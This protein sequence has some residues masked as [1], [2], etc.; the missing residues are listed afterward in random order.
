MLVTAC[1]SDQ[2]SGVRLPEQSKSA[3]ERFFFS[4]QWTREG[5]RDFCFPIVLWVTNELAK[6]L[7]DQAADFWSWRGGVFEFVQPLDWQSPDQPGG[8]SP[9]PN[10]PFSVS[11]S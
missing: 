6:E 8:T 11:R 3:E 1:G 7:A 10:P 2:L 9:L 5:L 4:L